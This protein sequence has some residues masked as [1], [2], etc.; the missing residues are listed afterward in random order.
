MQLYAALAATSLTPLATLRPYALEKPR[1][2]VVVHL[3]GRN[4]DAVSAHTC[5]GFFWH[6]KIC[7]SGVVSFLPNCRTGVVFCSQIVAVVS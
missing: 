3:A 6:R 2:P 7:R 5:Y 4:P 1:Q